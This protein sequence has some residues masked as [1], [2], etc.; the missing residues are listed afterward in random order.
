VRGGC[1]SIRGI[2]RSYLTGRIAR[3]SCSL[4]R[5]GKKLQKG[6]RRREDEGTRVRMFNDLSYTPRRPQRGRREGWPMVRGFPCSAAGNRGR[7]KRG[8]DWTPRIDSV[9]SL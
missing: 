1:L 6:P 8:R 4:L 2:S 3:S 9:G 7:T 5:L